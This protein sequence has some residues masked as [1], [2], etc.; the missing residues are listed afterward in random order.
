MLEKL[1]AFCKGWKK[2]NE[3]LYKEF[4]HESLLQMQ[5]PFMENTLFKF[6]Y[7]VVFAFIVQIM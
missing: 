1:W 7:D 2:K 6:S 3:L 5:S 4:R